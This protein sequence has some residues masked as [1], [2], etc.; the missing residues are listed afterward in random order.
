MA[1][2]TSCTGVSPTTSTVASPTS[3]TGVS[4]SAGGARSSSAQGVRQV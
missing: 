3:C 1:S 2:P 4:P